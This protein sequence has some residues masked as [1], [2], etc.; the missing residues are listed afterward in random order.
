MKYIN[1]N[2]LRNITKY[3]L[4]SQKIAVS[5]TNRNNK[6]SFSRCTIILYM[7]IFFIIS[8]MIELD[9]RIL[10]NS[11][12]PKIFLTI[13]NIK[14]TLHAV[15]PCLS[16]MSNLSWM[17]KVDEEEMRTLTTPSSMTCNKLINSA[18]YFCLVFKVTFNYVTGARLFA[19]LEFESVRKLQNSVYVLV[20]NQT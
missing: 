14:S 1:L 2:V 9:S 8:F 10:D 13:M 12:K 16:A 7:I 5:S 19:Y 17:E 15:R 3:D 6:A 20:C 18:L 4:K 11:S